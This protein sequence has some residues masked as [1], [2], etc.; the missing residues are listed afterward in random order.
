MFIWI[1][2]LQWPMVWAIL[3]VHTQTL[4]S[5]LKQVKANYQNLVTKFFHIYKFRFLIVS[6]PTTTSSVVRIAAYLYKIKLVTSID[7]MM[8]YK[9][10]N[11][12]RTEWQFNHRSP[13]DITFQYIFDQ[14]SYTE[15]SNYKQALENLN[16]RS[17]HQ[18]KTEVVP[19]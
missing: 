2:V 19:R 7:W 8:G 13:P 12:T 5:L 3:W 17:S 4:P 16:N 9:H 11:P 6:F 18:E 14:W 10:A 15:L 1:D